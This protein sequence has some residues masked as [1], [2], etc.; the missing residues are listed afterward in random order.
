MKS[1]KNQLTQVG[2]TEWPPFIWESRKD[3][4]VQCPQEVASKMYAVVPYLRAHRGQLGR[5]QK[6]EVFDGGV[7]YTYVKRKNL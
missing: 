4:N 2:H 3:T 7:L 5:P 1:V 6:T